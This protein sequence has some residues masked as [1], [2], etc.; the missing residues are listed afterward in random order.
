MEHITTSS[1]VDF[2]LSQAPNIVATITAHHLLYNRNDIFKGGICPHMYCLPIL[3]REEHRRALLAAATSGNPKFFIGL[4][5]YYV[6][7]SRVLVIKIFEL[8]I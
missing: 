3:K 5:D 4:Y 7:S 8:V 2:I 6:P 1:A